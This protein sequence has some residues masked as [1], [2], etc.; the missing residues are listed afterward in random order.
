RQAR[1]FRDLVLTAD[2]GALGNPEPAWMDQVTEELANVQAALRHLLDSGQIRE[3][4]RMAF[5]L[6][7]Y[8]WIRGRLREG[9][10]WVDDALAHPE[11]RHAGDRARLHFVA[12]TL[13]YAQGAFVEAGAR[14]QEGARLAR[15][16]GDD[17]VLLWTLTQ[18][19]HSAAVG[20]PGTAVV[21]LDAAESLCRRLD[22]PLVEPLIDMGRGLLA[23]ATGRLADADRHLVDCE[24]RAEQLGATWTLAIALDIHGMVAIGLGDP[25]RAET[26]LR[27]ALPIFRRLQDAWSTMYVLTT[28]ADAAALRSDG[29]RA[30]ALFGAAD[31]LGERCGA[32]ILPYLPELHQRCRERARAEVGPDV[33][34]RL[35]QESRAAPL[36]DIVALALDTGA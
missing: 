7:P 36:D 2:P 30:A 14:H 10:R 27:R 23:L 13:L 21:A 1:Y 15:E 12:G 5:S 8:W 18:Q 32:T 3:L 6:W 17:E 29:R 20:A 31:A 25:A 4:A 16:A 11:A 26:L 24:A 34:E 22:E 9:Q 19:A 33:F 35:R 28:L